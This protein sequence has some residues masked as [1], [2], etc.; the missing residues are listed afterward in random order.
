MKR[1]FNYVLSVTLSGAA[2]LSFQSCGG[3]QTEV[4]QSQIDSLTATIEQ[5]NQELEFYQS[6]LFLVSDGLDSI[7]R[8]D[9]DLMS[10][11][12]NR[13]K[14]I[15]RESIKQD[16]A[17]YADLL[18]R[19]RER[20]NELERQMGEGNEER[21]RMQ[22]LIT[23]LSQKIEERDA[24][25]QRLQKKVETQNFNVALLQDEINMLY[26][27]IATLKHENKALV[28]ENQ[29]QAEA[30]KV[31]EEMLN[32]AYYIVGT[33][34]ELKDAGVLS[35]R[36]LAKSKINVDQIDA[37]IFT[38]IDKRNFLQLT[39]P[40]KKITIKSQHPSTSYRVTSDKKGGVTTLEILDEIEFW[41]ITP[42]LIIQ[43]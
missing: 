3:N 23:M 13:E 26:S 7:A 29:T 20:I 32:E 9:K 10:V 41:S 12:S 35:S 11:A 5:N 36:F 28:T 16:L 25:I 34:R 31:G 40:S 6:C 33:S 42:F 8:A 37:S 24:T 19:Q 38:K 21:G 43:K 4:M 22:G 14:T 18:T 39:V 15:T 1:Y 17:A 2:I 30:I 27:K